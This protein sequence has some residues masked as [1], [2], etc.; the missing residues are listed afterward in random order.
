MV[1]KTGS[2]RKPKEFFLSSLERSKFLYITGTLSLRDIEKITGVSRSTIDVTAKREKWTELQKQFRED[3]DKAII[4]EAVKSTLS[5]TN[6]IN[7]LI[8][9]FVTEAKAEKWKD[10]GQA[11]KIALELDKHG[12]LVNGLPTESIE[13]SLTDYYKA[14]AQAKGQN[15]TE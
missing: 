5:N 7:Q 4:N 2:D 13:L 12:R 9:T 15:K 14:K 3:R 1:K 6:E 11:L 10:K 8:N